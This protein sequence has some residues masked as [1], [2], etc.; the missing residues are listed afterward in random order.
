MWEKLINCIKLGAEAAKNERCQMTNLAEMLKQ[1]PPNQM[2]QYHMFAKKQDEYKARV[3]KYPESLPEINWEHYEQNV[4]PEMVDWVKHYKIK[5]D[6]MHTLFENRHAMIDSK[7]Y[8]EEIDKQTEEVKK[9]IATYKAKSNER[10]EELQQELECMK[11]MKPYDQM[12]MEEFCY[13][14][15]HLAPD[16][17]NKP[18][19]WPHTPEEQTP[20][21]TDPEAAAALHEDP[22]EPEKKEPPPPPPPT[23]A[24][25]PAAVAVDKKPGSEKDT[26]SELA[27]K[28]SAFAKDLVAKLTV[29]FNTLKRKM[30]SMA[31]DVQEKAAATKAARAAGS[32]PKDIPKFT[33]KRDSSPD[34]CHQTIIRAAEEKKNPEVKVQHRDLTIE[35]DAEDCEPKPVKVDICK[36]YRKKQRMKLAC[37]AV[38]EEEEEVEGD[39]CKPKADPCR[40]KKMEEEKKDPCK[41]D[42]CGMKSRKEDS[43]ES[44]DKDPCDSDGDSEKDSKPPEQYYINLAECSKALEAK[45]AAEEA[46]KAPPKPSTPPKDAKCQDPKEPETKA[47]LSDDIKGVD[48]N[49]IFHGSYLEPER[50]KPVDESFIKGMTESFTDTNPIVEL[51]KPKEKPVEQPKDSK[52]MLSTEV[53]IADERPITVYPRLEIAPKASEK[54]IPPEMEG[55]DGK[56]PSNAVTNTVI[57]M[58]PGGTSLLDDSPVRADNLE[59]KKAAR[60]EALEAAYKSAKEQAQRALS[61]ASKAVTAATKLAKRAQSETGDMSA[62]DKEALA[63]AEKHATL[64][65]LLA[66]RAVSLKDDIGKVLRELK[67]KS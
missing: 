25:A 33:G 40:S 23:P 56:K 20:G 62:S 45:K 43:C 44:D 52:P 67:K 28:A 39:V 63:M 53:K 41:P 9:D 61:E 42:P 24:P 10:I 60:M 1:V 21:P 5:Y 12:T 37:K 35:A 7:R 4:R 6:K 47:S 14:R 58:A 38:Q 18:T 65:K 32:S 26:G 34:V 57:K 17:I 55:G 30:S 49:T 22:P 66:T 51:L 8:F 13:A 36:E 15:P 59:A 50:P 29:L 48:Q 46:K 27:E 11:A 31:K 64:A 54:E 16:F 3:R 2:A 19:F